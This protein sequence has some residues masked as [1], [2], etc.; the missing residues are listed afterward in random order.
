[1]RAVK[2]T[3]RLDTHMA[4]KMSASSTGFLL[5]L[6]LSALTILIKSSIV[7]NIS[8]NIWYRAT[9]GAVLYASKRRTN[10]QAQ[11]TAVLCYTSQTRQSRKC[12][13]VLFTVLENI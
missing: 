8:G 2:N 7:G 4:F 11:A 6:S 13:K 12:K 3:L 10:W 5:I 1:M 9:D